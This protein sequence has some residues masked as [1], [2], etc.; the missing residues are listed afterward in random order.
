M[1]AASDRRTLL[2]KT[3]QQPT[4][5]AIHE[6][7]ARVLLAQRDL[8]ALA[9]LQSV[10]DERFGDH[11]FTHLIAGHAA[12]ARGDAD[13]AAQRYR[14]ALALQPASG[15]AQ[16]NLV[17]LEVDLQSAERKRIA[18][19]AESP[20]GDTLPAADRINIHFAHARLLERAGEAE[21]AFAHYRLANDL[22]KATLDERGIRHDAASAERQLQAD[23]KNWRA[24]LFENPLPPPGIDL[25]PVFVTGLPRSGTT[26]VEQILASHP[27]V[28]AGGE[29]T[30]GPGVQQAFRQQ[31]GIGPADPLPSPTDTALREALARAREQYLNGLF[32]HGLDARWVVDKLP[33]NA[34]ISGFLRLLFPDAPIIHCRRAPQALAWSLY[35]ANFA[36]HEAWYHDLNDMAGVFQRHDR[37]IAHWRTLLPPPFIELTYETLVRAP[38]V[39]IPRLLADCGI[40]FDAATLQPEL[41]DRP[42]FTASHAQVRR[43]IH[44]AAIARWRPQAKHLVQFASVDDAEEAQPSSLNAER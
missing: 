13:A 34:R 12:K 27:Q 1:S 4:N 18:E 3:L 24:G 14:R 28:C 15:E 25:T 37:L 31:L 8:T 44:S 21:P 38:D 16:Y 42:V 26:L 30:L 6:Q 23:L 9:A 36:A 22:A 33:A 43:P 39:Q 17:D 32:E 41:L 10:L 2:Q 19:L 5:P 29:L 20:A 11:P 40:P 35:A 7:L